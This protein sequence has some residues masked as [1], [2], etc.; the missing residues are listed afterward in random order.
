M[1]EMNALQVR[2][3][4]RLRRNLLDWYAANRRDLP[5]RGTR[6]P[7]AIWV[8]EVM[9]QQTRTETVQRYYG[10]F[11]ACFPDVRSLAEADEERVLKAWEGLGYYRR[12]RSLHA[13]AREILRR[14]EGRMPGT[15]QEL[16]G[17][18]GIGLYTAGAIASIAYDE[19]VPAVDGNA[20]RVFSRLTGYEDCVDSQNSRKAMQTLGE[21]LV[22]PSDPSGWNQ[23]VMDLGAGICRPG[24]PECG[25]CPV[26]DVCRSGGTEMAQRLPVRQEKKALPVEMYWVIL[27]FDRNLRQVLVQ[28]R[29]E[30][31]LHGLWTFPMVPRDEKNGS[32][33]RVLGEARHVF[34]HRIWE[35]EIVEIP[36][37][38]N[39]FPMD[40]LKSFLDSGRWVTM[41]EI[42]QLTFPS[43]MKK[44]LAICRGR[45]DKD[46][47][48]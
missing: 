47:T 34:T 48:E 27:L 7:Y 18:P 8:S 41:E 17:I 15:F 6:D 32:L 29:E 45:M 23:A 43:A 1:M 9:L 24:R 21:Q 19:C 46:G 4:D 5:W 2:D 36:D 12:A 28:K 20:I 3:V 22:D 33:G 39:G 10:P 26:Y 35:M 30:T 13:G 11:L 38:E 42:E 31:L 16:L 14:F 25:I 44:A 37:I 40:A